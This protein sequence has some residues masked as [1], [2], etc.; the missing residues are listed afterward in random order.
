MCPFPD[1]DVSVELMHGLS[2]RELLRLCSQQGWDL[3]GLCLQRDQC[4]LARGLP[5][6]TVWFIIT[7]S[8][9]WLSL[10]HSHAETASSANVALRHPAVCIIRLM[11]GSTLDVINSSFQSN[12]GAL[13]EH[14]AV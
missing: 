14:S 3:S 12:A 2:G 5:A 10:S 4:P 9:A 8:P 13:L 6:G 7:L 11:I 1:H